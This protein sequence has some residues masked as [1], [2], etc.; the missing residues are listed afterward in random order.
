[1]ID[2]DKISP[3]NRCSNY[4]LI[5]RLDNARA[6]ASVY[7]GD[8][9]TAA[10]AH[11]EEGIAASLNPARICGIDG[12]E[13]T[14]LAHAALLDAD[15]VSTQVDALCR[16]LC[17]SP[18]QHGG[19]R[20]LLSVS[21]GYSDPVPGM[22]PEDR[23][24]ACLAARKRLEAA[25]SP[26]AGPMPSTVQGQARYRDDMTRA[27][28]FIDQFSGGETFFA[29]RP[30]FHS[31]DPDLVLQHEALLRV[32]GPQGEQVDCSAAYAA[33]ERLGFVHLLDRALALRVLEELESDPRAA[34]SIAISPQSLSFAL[35]GPDA[36][37]TEFLDRIEHRPADAARLTL[38]FHE[39]AGCRFWPDT[40]TF[41]NTLRE[42]GVRFAISGFGGGHAATRQLAVLRPDAVKLDSAFLRTATLSD[43]NR[44]RIGH[45]IGEAKT[46]CST[47]ILSGA[48][49]PAQIR[50]AVEEG[51]EW[52][53]GARQ[54]RAGIPR[55]RPSQRREGLAAG[56]GSRAAV[57]AP[58]L[59]TPTPFSPAP[60]STGRR[61]RARC[62]EPA[63]TTFRAGAPDGP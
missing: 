57:F 20:I 3:P 62:S 28:R 17:L 47:V 48:E 15:F 5:V 61:D 12:D 11:L 19:N 49:T 35:G 43:R 50:L 7:G 60:F 24:E 18:V 52:L 51:A 13:I 63:H 40:L 53:A 4:L 27:V 33:L 23:S 55:N 39:S 38:E 9:V 10:V 59:P 54:G 34:L 29:W 44:A 58:V 36:A 2:L 37:W 41:L 25:C 22:L 30:V 32:S 16:A 21:V 8:A 45:L 6:I 14:V 46:L 1:M 31:R 56:P 26:G 42:L